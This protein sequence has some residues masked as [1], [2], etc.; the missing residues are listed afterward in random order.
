[1]V[2]HGSNLGSDEARHL[3]CRQGVRTVQEAKA[4]GSGDVA[5]HDRQALQHIPEVVQHSCEAV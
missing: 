3:T 2:G 1:M 5:Q 4:A